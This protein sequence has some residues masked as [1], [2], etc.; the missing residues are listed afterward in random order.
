MDGPPTDP[1]INRRTLAELFRI[2]V[3]REEES[4]V[5]ITVSNLEIY[6]EQIYDLL[7][8]PSKSGIHAIESRMDIR[9]DANGRVFVEGL[10]EESC[11]TIDDVLAVIARGA[12]NRATFSTDM[13]EHSSRSHAI[14]QI[15]VRCSSRIT[16]LATVGKLS[17]V[18]LA[19]SE[20][21]DR[22][23]AVGERLKEATFINK[24]LSALGD[25]IEKL[26]AKDKSHI[27]FRNSKLTFLLA[28]SLGGDSKTLMFV[29]VAPGS[30]N[31]AESLCS[32]GFAIRVRS[33]KLQLASVHT[34]NP[35]VAQMKAQLAALQ[36]Q[37][38][39][40]GPAQ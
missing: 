7:A 8:E 10:A 27:P 37:V 11:R 19:G 5:Q 13:N 17:L 3:E 40:A 20:R 16:H 39:A 2:A 26:T 31:V 29:Q 38:A 1:G 34:E 4:E 32:L 23:N 22:S 25:V 35:E 24:S 30:A 21:L 33:V 15:R 12:G 6:N 36:A 14:L 18:D 28:D 9:Q